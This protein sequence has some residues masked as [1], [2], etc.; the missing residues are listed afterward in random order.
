ML[1]VALSV[2]VIPYHVIVYHDNDKV[3]TSHSTRAQQA[4]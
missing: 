1:L 2:Q 3:L 4:A